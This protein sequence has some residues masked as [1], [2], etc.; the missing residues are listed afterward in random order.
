MFQYPRQPWHER[1]HA[2]EMRRQLVRR[3]EPD[4]TARN[5]SLWSRL[6]HGSILLFAH[7]RASYTA[8]AAG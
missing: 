4:E 7:P 2:G 3:T 1:W 8:V 6:S 5:R